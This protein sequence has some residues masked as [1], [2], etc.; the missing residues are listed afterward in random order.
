[1]MPASVT[2]HNTSTRTLIEFCS[3]RGIEAA[4]LLRDSN[5]AP[6]VLE[7]AQARLPLNEM[8]AVWTAARTETGDDMLGIHVAAIVPFGSYGVL[9]YLALASADIGSALERYA[10]FYKLAH[11]GAELAV[12]GHGS[13]LHITLRADVPSAH[14]RDSI[15]YSFAILLSRLRFA[16]MQRWAPRLVRF[17]FAPWH[18]MAGCEEVFGKFVR[19]DAYE[20][21]IVLDAAVARLPL[22]SAD[23]ALCEVLEQR[24][25]IN[26]RQLA[27]DVRT[28]DAARTA[29]RQ[30]LRQGAT[31]G[32]VAT[33]IGT[34]QRSLQRALACEATSFRALVAEVRAD[35]AHDLLRH[36]D[37]RVVDVAAE[38]GFSEPAAFSRAFRQWT[39]V[40]PAQYR[41]LA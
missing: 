18:T 29:I 36:R 33:R 38:L 40:Y 12:E 35:L 13:S 22:L 23:A 20:H 31:I 1:M 16:T 7:S 2:V 27:A 9:D 3:R 37:C 26:V 10:R 24:A 34:S 19:F 39:G 17:G 5:L 4:R 32:S 11:G 14:M 6:G 25:S 30:L 15:A 28:S 41:R 21:A 8:L